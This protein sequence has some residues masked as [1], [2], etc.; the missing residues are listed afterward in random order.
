MAEL[1]ETNVRLND[2]AASHEELRSTG[3]SLRY[4]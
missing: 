4:P 1:S 3:Q 2:L